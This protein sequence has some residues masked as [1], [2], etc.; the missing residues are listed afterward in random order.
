MLHRMSGI[1]MRVSAPR[2]WRVAQIAVV[3]AA[4]TC[5]LFTARAHAAPACKV[6]GPRWT[7]YDAHGGANPKL[8]ATG[9]TYHVNLMGYSCAG[10]KVALKRIFARFPRPP[11]KPGVRL[12]GGPAGFICRSSGGGPPDRLFGG[13]C[14]SA[15]L[16]KRQLFAWAPYDP[17]LAR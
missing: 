11:F 14:G 5:A 16:S 9:T 4:T 1:A 8:D 7:H 2:A 6:T 10:A 15:N 13:Q 3:I 17:K 12:R